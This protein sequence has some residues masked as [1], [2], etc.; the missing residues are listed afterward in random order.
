MILLFLKCLFLA[1]YSY[2]S[3]LSVQL[4]V[5][6]RLHSFLSALW[7]TPEQCSDSWGLILFYG[8]K[9]FQL[10]N[11]QPDVSSLDRAP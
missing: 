11:Y 3:G 8:F 4:A 10:D 9:S 7:R 5:L 6:V 1:T 2:S